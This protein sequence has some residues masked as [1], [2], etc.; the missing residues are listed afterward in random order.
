M[1]VSGGSPAYGGAWAPYERARR[2]LPRPLAVVLVLAH[3]LFA[4]TVLG[5]LGVLGA[6]ESVDGEVLGRVAY[7]ALPGVAGFV[8]ARR[9]WTGDIWTWRGLLAVQGWLI[10]S[11]LNSLADDSGRG[12]TQLFLP[13]MIVVFLCRREVRQRNRSCCSLRRP[14]P[15]RGSPADLRTDPPAD[16]QRASVVPPDVPPELLGHDHERRRSRPRG[17]SRPGAVRAR[18]TGA[19][20]VA[21]GG[22]AGSSIPSS[23]ET[24]FN[25]TAGAYASFGVRGFGSARAVSTATARSGWE[26][27]VAARSGWE[28]VAAVAEGI[29]ALAASARAAT[30]TVHRERRL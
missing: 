8:L 23:P 6:V 25:A 16:P 21:E 30:A 19:G 12:F 2:P 3:V 9:T 20:S 10:V 4:F 11:A 27:A 17:T 5:G 29:S 28:A 22:G 14:A 15:P 24:S 13:V 26:A 7:A 18:Y 1:S